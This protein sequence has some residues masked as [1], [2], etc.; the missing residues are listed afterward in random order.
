MLPTVFN[1]NVGT[2]GMWEVCSVPHYNPEGIQLTDE[3]DL[4]ATRCVKNFLWCVALPVSCPRPKSNRT[5]ACTSGCIG[6]PDNRG[7]C[8]QRTSS[9][10]NHQQ[11]CS[12]PASRS[13]D[14]LVGAPAFHDCLIKK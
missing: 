4:L 8:F 6:S 2:A 7:A 11:L 1:C 10:D 14:P 12:P 5:Q 3:L 13:D 9:I